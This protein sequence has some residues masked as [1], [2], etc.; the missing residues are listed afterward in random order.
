[1]LE[2]NHRSQHIPETWCRF[3][4]AVLEYDVMKGVNNKMVVKFVCVSF[5]AAGLIF[6]AATIIHLAN[7]FLL[8]QRQQHSMVV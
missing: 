8:C 4:S 7:I 3:K 6:F 5:L 1:M 2:Q